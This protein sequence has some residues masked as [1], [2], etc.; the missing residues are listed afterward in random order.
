MES[1]LG[2][3]AKLNSADI[4]IFPQGSY[5]LSSDQVMPMEGTQFNS[6]YNANFSTD[7][8]LKLDR[9]LSTSSLYKAF[10]LVTL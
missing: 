2:E 3:F 4:Y 5:L 7:K 6:L 1:L 8:Q 10:I 9:D